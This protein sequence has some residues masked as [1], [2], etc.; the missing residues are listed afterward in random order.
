MNEVKSQKRERGP[1]DKMNE[2]K[3]RC[4]YIDA[5]S[6]CSSLFALVQDLNGGGVVGEPFL[7]AVVNDWNGAD[8]TL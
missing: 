7:K 2:V 4:S 8:K 5:G 1:R 6:S 3:S